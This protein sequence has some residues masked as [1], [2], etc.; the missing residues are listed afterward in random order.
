MDFK[1]RKDARAIMGI[2][3][4]LVVVELIELKDFIMMMTRL[5]DDRVIEDQNWVSDSFLD[6]LYDAM[7]EDNF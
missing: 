7:E 3:S 1:S 6:I 2:A 5:E 4:Y